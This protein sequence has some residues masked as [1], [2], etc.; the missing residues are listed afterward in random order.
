MTYFEI[1]HLNRQYQES[2]V[3]LLYD[4]DNPVF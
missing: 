4:P 1:D 3:V 2:E